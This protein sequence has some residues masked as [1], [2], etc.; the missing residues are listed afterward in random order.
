MK[1][2]RVGLFEWGTGEAPQLIYGVVRGGPA[3]AVMQ[4]TLVVGEGE[5][6]FIEAARR[7]RQPLETRD[8]AGAEEVL[9]FAVPLRA[10]EDVLGVLYLSGRAGSMA[11]DSSDLVFLEALATQVALALDRARLSER[12]RRQQEQERLRLRAEVDELRSALKRT[13]IIYRSGQM[14]ALLDRVRRVAPTDATVLISGESGT[15]KE[16][17]A[18]AIHELSPRRERPF[19]VV[20]CGAI[21]TTL[22]ESELFGHEKG[23]FTG[24]Q[25]R[26]PGRLVQAD[27]GTVLLDEI[28]ELPLEAQ[29]RLLRFVQDKYVTPVGGRAGRTVDVRVLAATNRELLAEVDAG[30]FR[31]D[32]YH[33]L[34]VV[35]LEIPPLRGRAD[36]VRHLAQHFCKMYSLIYGRPLFSFSPEAE[37]A[38]L[39]YTWP[40][41]VRELQNRV[42]RAVILGQGSTLTPSD[43]GLGEGVPAPAS[44]PAAA[45]PAAAVSATAPEA[46][47]WPAGADPW[48]ALR[49]ALRRQVQQAL[50][51]PKPLAPL[52][53]WLDEDLVLEANAV[54]GGV[55]SR[56]AAL[57]KMPVTTFRRRLEASLARTG[58]G[59]SSPR[60]AS[61]PEVRA[62]LSGLVALAHDGRQDLTERVPQ[63]LVEE[64]LLLLP[65]TPR[66]GAAL[67]GVS[68]PTFRRRC[69]SLAA[70]GLPGGV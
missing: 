31:A 69:E 21:P 13:E 30:R 9:G 7:R 62:A 8:G 16:V 61:W 17:F 54:G 36:D 6:R 65:D 39:R 58:A 43:L 57:L 34:N 42:M 49:M 33:R 4:Q 15:G 14:E 67:L 25:Q 26:Q 45:S 19:V 11:V 20:D 60:P 66:Q 59:W 52:G 40:G 51:G 32:L 47:P 27:R 48:A 50:A 24:A 41:N 23:A 53:R 3:A 28:G 63:V 22:I 37:S 70:G 18:R 38:I 55:A 44:L 46:P 12:Q 56:G 68:M 35:R 5:R 29:S 1:P 64:V 10:G 2:E